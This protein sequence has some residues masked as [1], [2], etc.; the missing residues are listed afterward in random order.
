[1]PEESASERKVSQ[2]E[3]RLV[4]LAKRF[5]RQT[6]VATKNFRMFSENHPFLKSS[7]TNACELLKSILLIKENAT[8]TFQDTSCL[9]EDIPIKNLDIKTYSF[10][11][12]AKECG[13]TSLTFIN[14]LTD[15]ELQAILKLI[16][17][18]P[19]AIKKEGGLAGFINAKN[20]S[21]IKADEVFFK[22]VSKKD[23]ESREAKKHLEDFLIVNYLMGKAAMSK[24]DISSLVGEVT[25]DPKRMGKILSDVAMNGPGSGGTGSGGSGSG[26]GSGSGAD[27]PGGSGS[28]KGYGGG[29]SGG[30][31]GPDEEGDPVL[32]SGSDEKNFDG[33]DFAKAGI[34]KIAIN[35]KNVQGKPYEDVK[36]HIGSLIMAMEPSI[37][38]EILKSKIPVSGTSDDMISDILREVSD[39]VVMEIIVSDVIGKKLSVVRV[40]KLIQRMIPDPAKR[41]K[42]FPILE[43]RLVKK[44]VSQEIC[45]KLLED[46]FWMD[47]NNEEKARQV[48]IE[49]PLFAVEIGLSDEINRLIENLLTEKKFDTIKI[50]IAKVFDNLVSNDT[51][52]KIRVLRD[53]KNTYMMLL[54]AKEYPY[55]EELLDIIRSEFRK[56]PDGA[57]RERFLGMLSDSVKLCLKNKWY[58]HLPPLIRAVGYENL[59]SA[60]SSEIKIEDFFRELIS[61]SSLDKRYVESIAKEMGEDAKMALR[62]MLMSIVSDDFESYRERRNITLILKDLGE[63]IEEIFIKELSSGK[64]EI[65]KNSL[66]AL[67]EIGTERSSDAVE[68]LTQHQD[69]EISNRAMTALKRIKS[70]K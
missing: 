48:S 30:T 41:A 61:D 6:S 34:E 4:S 26:I 68:K 45:S 17:D 46:K 44:G 50:V 67:C 10:L 49:P 14:G 35:I 27:R 66:E 3:A 8:F 33:I 47:M 62:N 29:G 64:I 43:E 9:L 15:S 37:R 5:I 36:K 60:I 11:N 16:S 31:S 42:I 56:N 13:I 58:S 59:K 1:M 39:D 55:K 70:R 53:I 57:I 65:L 24:D 19:N 23:E 21:H 54:Q 63:D 38:G 12:T 32:G 40:K 51:G 52:I 18:G 2:E 25:I 20:I 69:S 28:G 7:V 22:K